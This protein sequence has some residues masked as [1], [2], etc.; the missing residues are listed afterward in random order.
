[1]GSVWMSMTEKRATALEAARAV[2]RALDE[3]PEW[4]CGERALQV[5]EGLHDSQPQSVASQWRMKASTHQ[6]EL[7]LKEWALWCEKEQSLCPICR[8][9]KESMELT[10]CLGCG[11]LFE[12]EPWLFADG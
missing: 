9:W 6:V 12:G 8:G 5:L 1:M 2:L 7:F 4:V 3:A 10:L 11:N